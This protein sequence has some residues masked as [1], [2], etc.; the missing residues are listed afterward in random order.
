MVNPVL[1][2]GMFGSIDAVPDGRKGAFDLIRRSDVF[3]VL[4][5]VVV[6]CWQRLAMLDQLGNGTV[7]FDP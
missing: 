6:E 2:L 5:R 1:R 3:P 7:V 4:S